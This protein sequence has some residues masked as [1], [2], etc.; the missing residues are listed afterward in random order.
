MP[1]AALSRFTVVLLDMN[2]TFMFGGD[3]FGPEQDFAATYRR[4][5]GRQLP[6]QTVQDGV[7][8]CFD[9]LGVIY[10]DPARFDSFPAVLDALR[11]L[12][13]TRDL[14]ES[15]LRLLE[16]VIADHEL[17]AVSEAYAGAIKRLAATH[18]LGVIANLISRKEP[19]VNEF[20]RAGVLDRFTT[21]V[22]SSD[23]SSIKPS[24]KLFERALSAFGAPKSEVIFVGDSLRCDVGG[25]AG[26]GIASIWINRTGF[27]PPPGSP[28]P[29]FVI[30][31]LLELV[32]SCG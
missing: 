1:R 2:G 23:T 22:F 11:D 16:S 24:R 29:T 8:A 31:D 28:E 20:A 26:A 32:D 25:A 6:D 15:E 10:E 3:R 13:T 12:P 21:T 7:R 4:L 30:K 17:G 9:D 19:W 18:R 27:V 5:G 14:P